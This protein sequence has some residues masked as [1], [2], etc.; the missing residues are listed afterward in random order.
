MDLSFIVSTTVKELDAREP[1]FYLWTSHL[2]NHQFYFKDESQ[3]HFLSFLSSFYSLRQL[4]AAGRKK[5]RWIVY[6]EG[7]VIPP[8]L[9]YGLYVYSPLSRA[10]WSICIYTII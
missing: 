8:V 6:A 4:V 9:K 1:F 10:S 2:E 7:V 5:E 3:F